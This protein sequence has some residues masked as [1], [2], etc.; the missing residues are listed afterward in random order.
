MKTVRPIY[1]LASRQR[2][3]V[4]EEFSNIMSEIKH[5]SSLSRD[6]YGNQQ[7]RSRSFNAYENY[8][9]NKRSEIASKANNLL[10]SICK[11]REQRNF[12]STRAD[13]FNA[14]ESSTSHHRRQHAELKSVL[15]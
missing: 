4:L 6:E 1:E 5:S 2:Q 13:S 8:L 15:K 3:T 11:E 12:T 10:P 7:T 14:Y 9:G